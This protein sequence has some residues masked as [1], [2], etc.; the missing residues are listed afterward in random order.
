MVYF[1]LIWFYSESSMFVSKRRWIL[2][3]CGTTTPLQCLQPLLDVAVEIA[4]YEEIEDLFYSRKNYKR[5]ELQ[6]SPH[7][8]FEEE[9]AYLD[10]YFDDGRA[11]SLGSVNGECW[12]LY[13]VCRGGGSS[14]NCLIES[15]QSP[16]PDQTIEILMTELDP[17]IMSIFNKEECDSAKDATEVNIPKI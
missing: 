13:T 11:Y 5:P 1:Y 9:V 14:T 16:D 12:Y 6:C 15:L 2:K 10:Q 8:G 3:T 17:D 7:R 4:G